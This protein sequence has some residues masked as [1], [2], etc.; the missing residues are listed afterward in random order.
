M[1]SIKF[2]RPFFGFL[3]LTSFV[4]GQDAISITDQMFTTVKS[5]KTIQY[6]FE[7]KERLAQG[8]THV[9]RSTFK[10]NVSPLQIYVYQHA[11]KKGLQCLYVAGKNNG[12][13]KINPNSFPWVN[14]NLE[15]ESELMLQDRHHSIFDAGFTYTS[16]L[17]E[18]LLTKYQTQKES[19]I[20]YN[21][22]L[23]LQGV[24]CY[25]L[26]FTN[27]NYKL[28]TYTTQAKETP[29][30]IAKKN[31]LNFYS[32]IENNP[33]IKI[34]PN[35]EFKPG[36]KLII[37]NDYASKMELFIQ[38][39][40]YYPVYLKIFDNKGVYEEFYFQQVTINPIFKEIDFSETNPAYKF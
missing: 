34:K 2:I 37:P 8:K 11:P 26:V 18:Y 30:S 13:V 17:I 27:P 10:I 5:V 23:K 1:F 40:K 12:K 15:P 22:I 14:L 20:K 33:S 32:I 24:E 38:K 21:G 36:T 29:L 19:L 16:S 4:N 9:E 39:E 3:L 31:H 28:V 6:T 7:A 35:D 25:Y